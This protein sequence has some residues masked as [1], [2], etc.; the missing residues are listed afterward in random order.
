M[1][2]FSRLFVHVIYRSF[3]V[4][5]LQAPRTGSRLIG[6]GVTEQLNKVGAKLVGL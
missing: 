6:K 3:N 4:F 1:L 2:H 5:L